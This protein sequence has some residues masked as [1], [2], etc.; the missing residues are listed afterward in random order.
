MKLKLA[1]SL[2][3]LFLIAGS[4]FGQKPEPAKTPTKSVETKSTKTP[5]KTIETKSTPLSVKLPT[6]QEVFAKY[7][8]ALGGKEANEKI[9]TRLV[10]GTIELTPVG[11]KG[12]VESYMSAPDKSYTKSN[13]QGVGEIIE[14]FDGTTAWSLN[15]IQGNR[16]KDGEELLQT[17]L[18]NNFYRET[19][20]NKLYPKME[21][22]GTEKVGDKET[23]V[24]VA[25]PNGLAPETFYFDVKSGLLVRADSIIVTPEGKMPAKTFYEDVREVDGIK[26]PYKI[27]VV[28]P[29]FEIVTNITEIKHGITIEGS[30]FTKPKA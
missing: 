21:V 13:L 17:K 9:K 6:A 22:K 19:N 15:P 18:I 30:K 28:L 23:Y 2:S 4:A 10:K 5:A 20:L 11:I 26:L 29:Q 1:I 27:R 14:G 25:T 24:V 16:D 8:Q 3:A 7:V 12:T